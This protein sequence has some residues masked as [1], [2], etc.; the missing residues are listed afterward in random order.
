[1]LT[2]KYL[3]RSAKH[4][5]GKL[6]EEY[7]F[8]AYIKYYMLIYYDLT[9]FAIMKFANADSDDSAFDKKLTVLAIAVIVS[10]IL[11]PLLL[12]TLI[13]SRFSV[14]RVKDTKKSFNVLI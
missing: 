7:R 4:N 14:L 8:N 1:M 13:H 2:S 3:Y 9:Y 12:L 11:V 5:V 10:S 6:L